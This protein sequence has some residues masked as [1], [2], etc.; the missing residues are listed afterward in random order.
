MTQRELC[1]VS[2]GQEILELAQEEKGRDPVHFAEP[3]CK[4]SLLAAV[5]FVVIY[6]AST[7]NFQL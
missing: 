2:R 7:A 5:G 4:A 3:Q 6:E 1:K